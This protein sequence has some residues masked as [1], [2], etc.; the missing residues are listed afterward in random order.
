MK[1]SAA[2]LLLAACCHAPGEA[3]LYAAADLQSTLRPYRQALP[4]YT[5]QFPRDYFNHPE[6]RTEW[7]YYTGNLR[8]QNG[9]RFGFE[10]TFFR[11]AVQ[12]HLPPSP[13]VWDIRDVWMAHLALTDID[14][15]QFLNTERLNRSGPG[16][17]GVD[18]DRGRIWNGNWS[19][20]WT[21]NSREQH[22]QAV[23]ERFS[24]DLSL[25]STK[26]PVLHG[27]NGLSQKSA[28]VGRASYYVSLT[29]LLTS[30]TIT[31][32]GKPYQVE[33]LAWMDH[34]FF[35]HSLE[36]NQSGWDWFSLQ[37]NDGTELMLYRL[38][39]KDGTVEPYSSGTFIDANGRAQFLSLNEFQLQPG[40]LWSSP[41]TKARYPIEWT[42]RVPRL[43]LDCTVSTRLPAQELTDKTGAS[44]TYWEGAVEAQGTRGGAPI[45]G[46]GYLEMTGYAG[47]VRMGD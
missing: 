30:G 9:R 33:G 11:H 7:W 22:L 45:K 47:A 4:G 32:D 19:V 23:S 6:F 5:W 40:K 14:G 27:Q 18:A 34:E 36:S 25:R 38:R 39:R 35:S 31:L 8:A 26:P 42:I 41:E 3:A 1:S 13:N 17:A 28:G 24:L 29:R 15:K 37:F 46:A 12:P 2:L 21:P 43:S 20:V 44:P 16:L 10:L